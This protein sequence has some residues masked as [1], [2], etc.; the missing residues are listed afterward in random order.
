MTK[1]SVVYLAIEKELNSC[2]IYFKREGENS[3]HFISNKMKSLHLFAS[4]V[5]FLLF[6]L[7][8]YNSS[9]FLFI[10]SCNF[11]IIRYSAERSF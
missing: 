2:Y 11:R 9:A 6:I 7:C 8:L 10:L 4:A 3:L 1:G 5:E